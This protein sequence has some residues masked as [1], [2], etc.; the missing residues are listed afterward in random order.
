MSLKRLW[1]ILVLFS[2]GV[3]ACAGASVGNKLDGSAWV[4][5]SLDGANPV[6]GGEP[7]LNFEDGLVRGNA[8]CNQFG[9]EYEIKGNTLVFAEAMDMTA[10]ACLDEGIMDQEQAYMR[11]LSGEMQFEST[12]GQ[13]ILTNQQGNV[14]IFERLSPEG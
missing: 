1:L 3:S 11:M 6:P 14:L 13:L 10:M 4:L 12:D 5:T 7:T 8:S 9:G 2:F